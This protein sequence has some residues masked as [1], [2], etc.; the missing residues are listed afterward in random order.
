VHNGLAL[1]KPTNLA[2]A[3]AMLARLSGSAHEVLTGVCLLRNSP[4]G[5]DCWVSR[6][7]VT[8]CELTPAVISTYIAKVH[9]LDK[10]GAYAI[11]EHGEMLISEVCGLRSNVIGLPV[12]EVTARLKVLAQKKQ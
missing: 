7:T 1:G 2:E 10:A 5:E 11:Q 3:A 6:T 12:E 4:A 9:T 8:F